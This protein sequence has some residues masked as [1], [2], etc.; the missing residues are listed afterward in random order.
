MQARFPFSV[1]R[2]PK[3]RHQSSVIGQISVKPCN[4]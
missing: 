1:S 2:F 4:R 3:K